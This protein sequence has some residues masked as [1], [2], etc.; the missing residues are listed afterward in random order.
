[1]LAGEGGKRGMQ[2]AADRGGGVGMQY[3]LAGSPVV[4]CTVIKGGNADARAKNICLTD[5]LRKPLSAYVR[6]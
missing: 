1:M 3:A 5:R 2:R 4:S 6:N